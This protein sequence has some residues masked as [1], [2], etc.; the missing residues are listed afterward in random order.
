[1]GQV[2]NPKVTR[3]GPDF[4]DG[5]MSWQCS[6]KSRRDEMLIVRTTQSGPAP[7]GRDVLGKIHFPRR[8]SGPEHCAPLGLRR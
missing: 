4:S 6:F 5:I 3:P 2:L 1:M 8:L 7:A